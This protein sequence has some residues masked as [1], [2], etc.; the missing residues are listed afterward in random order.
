MKLRR[1]N[2]V[3]S[4]N[5][6]PATWFNKASG[7]IILILIATAFRFA[8]LGIRPYYNDELSAL[9]RLENKATLQDLISESIQPDAHP[10]GVQV[11]L[12]YW[13]RL[14]GSNPFMVRFPFAVAG[15]ISVWLF[16]LLA[17]RW[18]GRTAALLAAGTLAMLQ[19][20]I[21]YSQLIRPYSTG[22]L[23]VIAAA[24]AWDKLI[25]SSPDLP[26]RK[27]ILYAAVMA[28][29]FSLAMY[30]H[31]FSF[32]MAAMIGLTGLP[33]LKRHNLLIYLAAGIVSVVLFIPHLAVSMVQVSR[34]GLALWLPPPHKTWIPEHLLYL[35]NDSWWLLILVAA[36]CAFMLFKPSIR[37]WQ[38]NT[39]IR[40][41]I[42]LAWYIIPLVFAFIYSLT[43]NPILQNS[44]MLFAFPFLLAVLF[45]GFGNKNSFMVKVFAILLP[46]V[47]AAQLIFGNRYYSTVQYT[48]FKRTSELICSAHNE[49]ESL[50]WA[51]DVNDPWYIHHYL[52]NDCK[53]D[54]ALFY[55]FKGHESIQDLYSAMVSLP[56]SSFSYAW[57]RPADPIVTSVIRQH[58]P[59]LVAYEQ[60]YPYSE[61]FRFS[62]IRP[63]NSVAGY[64]RDSILLTSMSEKDSM[65]VADS[66]TIYYPIFEGFLPGEN[67]GRG[68][69]LL[70][71]EIDS[72][73]DQFP[74]D[75]H[76]VIHPLKDDG[77][78]GEWFGI[79]L[80]N[81]RT[82]KNS[83]FYTV[84]M[85][86]DFNHNQ[87][88]KCYLWNPGKE[89]FSM[90][91]VRL[92]WLKDNARK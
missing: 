36:P 1:F 63:T 83:F 58:F 53:P 79:R 10:A 13:T 66:S 52:D 7:L 56:C 48:D 31:Y 71:C 89:S 65:L 42:A 40:F 76:I 33:L 82:S 4:K 25:F 6:I 5:L 41:I 16:F 74:S 26:V 8:C 20:P 81:T 2:K 61:F 30:N 75:V 37:K 24:Y 78:A 15:I 39:R 29:S 88:L 86:A 3:F 50:C 70:H 64:T 44:I 77:T 43:V 12:W 14:A 60:Q 59:Y 34:G 45:S 62:K 32:F 9:Y 72:Y 90:K 85:P 68:R 80:A 91:S 47:M 46:I 57:L 55:L 67:P 22:M 49:K 11:F 17:N 38:R 18:F 27:K 84:Y 92:L 54:S 35:F 73:S 69:I 87:R 23:F 21:L 28:L 19:F 51:V